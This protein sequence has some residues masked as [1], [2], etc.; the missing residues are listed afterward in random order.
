MS[1]QIATNIPTHLE[2]QSHDSTANSSFNMN[3]TSLM[4]PPKGT[5]KLK[6]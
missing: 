2:S 5:L 4:P 3:S 6:R 1:A